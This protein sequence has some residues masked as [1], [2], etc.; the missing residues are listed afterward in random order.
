MK[1]IPEGL[2]ADC[3][4]DLVWWLKKGGRIFVLKSDEYFCSK[5][6]IRKAK[7]LCYWITHSMKM[8]SKNQVEI[9][10]EKGF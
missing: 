2:C 1:N 6:C 9:R 5:K 7:G 8:V 3:G 10:Q 4:T